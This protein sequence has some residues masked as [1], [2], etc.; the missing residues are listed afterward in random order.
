MIFGGCSLVSFLRKAKDAIKEKEYGKAKE[1]LLCALSENPDH[2]ELILPELASV[3]Y[4]NKEFSLA[5]KIYHELLVKSPENSTLLFRVGDCETKLKLWADAVSSLYRLLKLKPSHHPGR[6][7]LSQ[8]LLEL[9]R[10]PEALEVIDRVIIEQDNPQLYAQKAHVLNRLKRWDEAIREY[11]RAINK[12]QITNDVNP[13]WLVRLAE[14]FKNISDFDSALHFYLKAIKIKPT[15]PAWHAA[16]ALA[17]VKTAQNAAAISCYQQAVALDSSNANWFVELGRLLVDTDKRAAINAYQRA[18]ELGRKALNYE[19]AVLSSDIQSMDQVAPDVL[20]T[21]DRFD[22]AVKLIYARNLLGE[23]PFHS[24]INSEELYLR[25]IYLRTKGHEPD[26]LEKVT[27]QDYKVCFAELLKNINKNGFDTSHAIPIAKDCCLLNGAHRSTVGVALKLPTIPVVFI[28]KPKGIR[29]DFNWF[30]QR[31]F[32]VDELNEILLHWLEIAEERAHIL[33]LWPAV[34]NCWEDI[35]NTIAAETQLVTYRDISFTSHGMS[36][37]VKDVYSIDKVAEY[38]PSILAKADKLAA[39]SPCVRVLVVQADNQQVNDLKIGLRKAYEHIIPER[40][41]CTIHASADHQEA[42]HLGRIFFHSPT[43]QLLRGRTNSLSSHLSEWISQAKE[44]LL[45]RGES[46]LSG[47]AVGGAV[48]DAYNIRKADDLDITVTSEVR[49]RY[50]SDK[51][52]ALNDNIDIVNKDYAKSVS[53]NIDDDTLLSDRALH[54]YVRGF[55]FAN[56][57]VVR[58]RKAFSQRDKDLVDLEKI[59]HY[60][61]DR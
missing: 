13:L 20:F 32:S 52:C 56:V 15:V 39:Y 11:K 9:K 41:F 7:K 58:K 23:L 47:C 2:E 25:H 19:I 5:I 38:M 4:F 29:W 45:S 36:E 50:F 46:V 28:D 60:F 18:V 8:V 54:V 42:M 6:I 24:G 21:A 40:L 57:D 34:S 43:L 27:L 22:L 55:K 33:I 53:G 10:F 37:L 48:L 30:M 3:Y 31:G 35:T 49:S 44:V 59:S 17:Y 16:L 26:N 14:C 61:W 51:A 1:I 12:A